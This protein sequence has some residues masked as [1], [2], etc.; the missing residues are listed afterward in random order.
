MANL[1]TVQDH[2]DTLKSGNTEAK[3]QKLTPESI[4][5]V[6][7]FIA[8]ERANRDK[9]THYSLEAQFHEW[10][11]LVRKYEAD[12]WTITTATASATAWV[13]PP[14]VLSPG[15]SPAQKAAQTW[16]TSS[17]GESGA[18]AVDPNIEKLRDGFGEL[19]A[20]SLEARV[21]FTDEVLKNIQESPMKSTVRNIYAGVI[22]DVFRA[23]GHN[24]ILSGNQVTIVPKAWVDVVDLQEKLQTL[25]NTGRIPLENLKVGMLYSSPSFARYVELK[26]TKTSDGKTLIDP[27]ATPEDFMTYVADRRRARDKNP[28]L[29][30]IEKSRSMVTR[31]NFQ[32]A[33]AWYADMGQMWEWVK[34]NPDIVKDAVNA[35]AATSAPAPVVNPASSRWTNSSNNLPTPREEPNNRLTGRLLNPVAW[36]T[37]GQVTNAVYESWKGLTW[38]LK[39]AL[40]VGRWDPLF[41]AVIGL[42]LIFGIFKSVQKFGFLKTLWG[43]LVLGGLNNIENILG[44]D[45]ARKVGETVDE[46]T[47]KAKKLAEEAAEKAKAAAAWAWAAASGAVDEAKKALQSKTDTSKISEFQKSGMKNIESN[48]SLLEDIENHAKS[49]PNQNAPLAT[50]LEVLHKDSVQN[51]TLDKIVY[52]SHQD[53]SIFSEK[54]DSQFGDNP[55]IPTNVSR[56]LLKQ[57]IRS[58]LGMNK[59]LSPSGK[60]SNGALQLE[61]KQDWQDFQK[62]YPKEQWK[63][64]T[65]KDLISE[66][67]KK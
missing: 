60:L 16:P 32:A 54:P 31:T 2:L 22:F 26:K 23:S 7:T 5:D 49:N 37:N 63:D 3:K 48:K 46:A 62:K 44:K 30:T 17:A 33:I 56:R 25:V 43:G 27:K 65:L 36:G 11:D 24:L 58:Y 4:A 47:A 41:Q 55:D 42:A 13:K 21:L 64:K 45:A 67:Y 53:F 9:G 40:S 34:K 19:T 6:R 52:T 50:Y 38:G 18:K 10:E 1:F 51:I 29:E 20:E 15:G 28:D 35:G 61:G 14:P 39:D 59:P 8:Q 66:I 57:V 12:R